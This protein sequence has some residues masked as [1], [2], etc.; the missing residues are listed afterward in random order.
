[1]A[2]DTKLG[3]KTVRLE[4]FSVQVFPIDSLREQLAVQG[5]HVVTAADKAVLRRLRGLGLDPDRLRLDKRIPLETKQE[6]A[7]IVE[8]LPSQPAA[9]SPTASEARVRELE[10]ALDRSR[11]EADGALSREHGETVRADI[12][13][14]HYQRAESELAQLRERVATALVLLAEPVKPGDVNEAREV[15]R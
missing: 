4:L 12:A 5:L 2:A 7:S 3:A 8:D 13:V 10:E 15:L 6:L 11:K 14:E 1:M 9:P